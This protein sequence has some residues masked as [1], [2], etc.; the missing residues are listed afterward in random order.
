M[1]LSLIIAGLFSA[2]FVKASRY[3]VAFETS[4]VAQNCLQVDA[5][6]LKKVST[7]YHV[8]R[9][10]LYLVNDRACSPT[11]QANIAEVCGGVVS[12]QCSE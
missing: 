10:R 7:E 11:I 5:A 1:K 8:R 2:M 6:Y 12:S 3:E 9:S 4:A